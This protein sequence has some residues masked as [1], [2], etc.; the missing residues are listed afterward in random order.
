MATP[1]FLHEFDRIKSSL[2]PQKQW[3]MQINL[4]IKMKRERAIIT[5]INNRHST[6]KQA[7]E[8]LSGSKMKQAMVTLPH[9]DFSDFDAL[10][11]ALRA[12]NLSP[13]MSELADTFIYPADYEGEEEGDYAFEN[14]QQRPYRKSSDPC[15]LKKIGIRQP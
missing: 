1:T 5:S 12:V 11:D 14:P 8:S 4:V 3:L 6:A 7:I 9:F 13:V 10:S 2:I 15:P